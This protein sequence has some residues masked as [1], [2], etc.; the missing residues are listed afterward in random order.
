LFS[1][2]IRRVQG[3]LIYGLLHPLP[4][5]LAPLPEFADLVAPFFE[6]ILTTHGIDTGIVELL[7]VGIAVGVG[8]ADSD[9]AGSQAE[10]DRDPDSE[11]T[12]SAATRHL[13]PTTCPMPPTSLIFHP[14]PGLIVTEYVAVDCRSCGACTVLVMT[15]TNESTT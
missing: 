8:L 7:D 15:L 10:A 12:R 14:S 2:S 4:R 11:N 3:V 6:H 1:Q 5:R 9:N 13:S